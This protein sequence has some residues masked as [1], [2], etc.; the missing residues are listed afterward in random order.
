[1]ADT[2]WFFCH[3]MSEVYLQQ[4]RARVHVDL[5]LKHQSFPGNQFREGL[6]LHIHLENTKVSIVIAVVMKYTN[7]YPTE[8][9]AETEKP[10][11]SFAYE[12]GLVIILGK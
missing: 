9:C 12:G 8:E 4:N 3:T 2:L 5:Y 10:N 6:I 11:L 1:M 7:G